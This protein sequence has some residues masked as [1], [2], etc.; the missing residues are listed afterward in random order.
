MRSAVHLSAKQLVLQPPP[1]LTRAKGITY[2]HGTPGTA[3]GILGE[4][5]RSLP[6]RCW[7]CVQQCGTV[8]PSSHPWESIQKNK[9]KTNQ[10]T[11]THILLLPSVMAGFQPQDWGA[12]GGCNWWQSGVSAVLT[13]QWLR[14][15]HHT[16]AMQA[17]EHK[18]TS[19]W[20]NL[21]A[22]NSFDLKAYL[23]QSGLFSPAGH[24]SARREPLHLIN[25]VVVN[26]LAGL[27]EIQ[28][29]FRGVEPSPHSA[30]EK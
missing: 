1:C 7:G 2:R 21:F 27:E 19:I 23:L 14:W 9:S 6:W 29:K 12:F 13:Q 26:T 22:E 4:R 30:R 15:C 17:Q 18:G 11:K 5:Q 16:G 8:S 25:L 20:R 24:H 10:I 28:E 3:G